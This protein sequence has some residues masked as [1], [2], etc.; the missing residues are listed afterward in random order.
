MVKCSVTTSMT[1]HQN[2]TL[3]YHSPCYLPWDISYSGQK[4][5][6]GQFSNIIFPEKKIHIFLPKCLKNIERC[7]TYGFCL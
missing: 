2:T 4:V 1:T 6:S 5:E 7:N 3:K